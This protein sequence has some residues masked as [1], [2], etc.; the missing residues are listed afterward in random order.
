MKRK[1]VVF[2]ETKQIEMNDPSKFDPDSDEAYFYK[3]TSGPEENDVI[4]TKFIWHRGKSNANIDDTREYKGGFSFYYARHIY[5]DKYFYYIPPRKNKKQVIP[6]RYHGVGKLP[7]PDNSS[8][9]VVDTREEVHGKKYLR[10]I[11]SRYA[12]EAEKAL[13]EHNKERIQLTEELKRSEEY[14]K[15]L[16]KFRETISQK[17]IKERINIL[18][19]KFMTD[20]SL[21][22]INTKIIFKKE[23]KNWVG[24]IF[25]AIQYIN[26]DVV[27]FVD[28]T[29]DDERV[30]SFHINK[31]EI[32]GILE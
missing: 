15:S 19:E 4:V 5:E 30:K 3:D 20:N 28:A 8:L 32:E 12:N 18:K 25:N 22:P 9:L 7:K 10:I 31:D 11:S 6:G 26:G 27:Y 2:R 23:N 29:S 13:Y 21:I 16:S 17:K 14:Q 1:F 24:V